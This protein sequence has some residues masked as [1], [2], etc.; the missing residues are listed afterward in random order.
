MSVL[1]NKGIIKIDIVLKI[2]YI[3][4]YIFGRIISLGFDFDFTYNI[5]IDNIQKIQ[6]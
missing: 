5:M 1:L 3:F 6:K 4:G 2:Y